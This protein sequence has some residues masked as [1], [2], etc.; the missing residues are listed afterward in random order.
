MAHSVNSTS[1]NPPDANS[2]E[3][4]DPTSFVNSES[5]KPHIVQCFPRHDIL[6]LDDSNFIQWQQ[7]VCLIVE[8]YDLIGFLMGR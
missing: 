5:G 4:P 1:V 3:V 8:G 2:M 7:H 6:K